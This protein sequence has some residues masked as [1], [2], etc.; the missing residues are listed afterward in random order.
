MDSCTAIM[1]AM[2]SRNQGS[3][4]HRSCTRA[5]PQ[6]RRSA[7]ATKKT[8]SSVGEETRFS[9]SSSASASA[10]SE[11][12][13]TRPLR[14]FSSERIALPNASSN[15]RPIDMT[16]PTAFMRVERVVSVPLNFSKA[17]RGILTTQ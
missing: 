12:P 14:P 4:P 11:P 5:T 7:S 13:A 16:S 6:P 17:K 10:P 1:S 2:R 9:S 3:M 15:V 8:R